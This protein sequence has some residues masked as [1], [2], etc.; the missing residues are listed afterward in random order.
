MLFNPPGTDVHECAKALKDI[1]EKRIKRLPKAPTTGSRSGGSSSF[2]DS[3]VGTP[4]AGGSAADQRKMAD[5]MRKMEQM[6]RD[7]DIVKSKGSSQKKP[8]GDAAGKK[9]T[10]NNSRP[11]T[12]EEKRSLS[13][14]INKLP[15]EKLGKVVEII[16]RRRSNVVGNSEEI[17]ID[18]DVLDNATLKELDKYV[19]ETLNPSKPKPAAGSKA[20]ALQF[21]VQEVVGGAGMGGIK[22]GDSDLDSDSSDSDAD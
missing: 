6:Q 12:F 14:N 20:A 2:A 21:A 10:N 11:M 5:M 22:G 7:L 16:K 13:L 15:H 3:G 1:A 9:K 17:E 18:I 19:K 8:A 4:T